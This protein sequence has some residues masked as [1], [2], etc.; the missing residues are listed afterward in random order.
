MDKEYYIV[1]G[2]NRVGP[3]T[4]AQ[5]AE[6]GIEPSTLVWTAGMPDW[7]RADTMPELAPLLAN[8]TS[9]DEQESAFGSYARP[10]ERV[11]QQPYQLPK[12]YGAYNPYNQGGGYPNRPPVSTNWKT[13][14]IVATVVGFL[15][16]C[17][18]GLVG[19]IAIV[20]ASKAENAMRYGDMYTAESA[21]S[22]ARTLCI[23]SFI[24]SGIG[25]IVNILSIAKIINL[26]LLN[27]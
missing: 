17:I 26:G 16:S 10:E 7:A 4:M 14:A 9:I 25:L 6:R 20:Q 19:I 1:V 18:G 2:D 27:I 15:L 21:N 11:A 5:L 12:Q 22:T 3:L 23:I 24:L 13:L 8:R